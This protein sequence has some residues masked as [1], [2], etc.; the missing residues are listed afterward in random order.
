MSPNDAALITSYL[1][2]FDKLVRDIA[3][4]SIKAEVAIATGTVSPEYAALRTK[5]VEA[6]GQAL[7]VLSHEV[8][9]CARLAMQ[10]QEVASARRH[11]REMKELEL[12]HARQMRRMELDELRDARKHA[13]DEARVA[14]IEA[15]NARDRAAR[16]NGVGLD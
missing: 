3:T 16:A 1:N 7:A 9:Q 6:S 14:R 8:G 10:N 15:A 4:E 5:Q 11:E 12:E 2:N 13:A